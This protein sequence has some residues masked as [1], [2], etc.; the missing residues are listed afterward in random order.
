MIKSANYRVAMACG[1]SLIALAAAAP[2]GANNTNEN[3]G[4]PVTTAAMNA[5]D[6]NAT[7]G[8]GADAGWADAF[9]RP[10]IDGSPAHPSVVRGVA[11]GTA[12]YLYVE[13]ENTAFRSSDA[14]VVA[15]NPT[16]AAGD[17]HKLIIRPCDTIPGGTCTNDTSVVLAPKVSSITGTLAT[18]NTST[19]APGAA[20]AGVSV[21]SRSVAAGATTKWGVEIKLDRAALGIPGSGYFPF[22][23]NAITT[24]PGSLGHPAS[25]I[26]FS[27]PVNSPMFSNASGQ[28]LEN[29][30]TNEPRWGRATLDA[31]LIPAG[32][33]IMG[34]SNSGLDPSKISLTQPNKFTATIANGAGGVALPPPAANISV[35]FEMTQFGLAS[36]WDFTPVPNNTAPTAAVTIAPRQYQ[37]FQAQPWTPDNSAGGNYQGTGQ[38][39]F[40]W[41]G[42]HAHQCINI[43]VMQGGVK[44]TERYYNMDFQTV[45]SPFTSTLMI[46]TGSW[47]KLFPKAKSITLTENFFNTPKDFTWDTGIDGARSIGNHQ[48]I[49]SDFSAD[50]RM[51]QNKILVSD[52]LQLPLRDYKLDTAQLA[53]GQY[54]KIPVQAGVPL[55]L[56]AD[57]TATLGRTSVGPAGL[58]LSD[59][60]FV[61]TAR[62]ARTT[63]TF[64]AIQPGRVVSDGQLVG[65]FDNFRTVVPIQNG[66]TLIPPRGASVL[67]VGIA[68]NVAGI[69]G[70]WRLQAVN[71]QFD[72]KLVTGRIDRTIGG[73]F[74][75]IG[76]NLPTYVVHGMLD[77]GQTITIDGT[78]YNVLVPVGSYG[79]YVYRVRKGFLLPV[80]VR[81]DLFQPVRPIDPTIVQPVR[82]VD[83]RILQPVR[84]DLVQP[85]RPN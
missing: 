84:P 64:S 63:R 47:R 65:S 13:A 12:V 77:I 9:E 8:S 30:S 78:T 16:G 32:L 4:F 46:G 61:R 82:P 72:R 21:A 38:N 31:S 14:V 20:P 37:V 50:S 74:L 75:P 85:V 35:A 49:V 5:P 83:P 7:V 29:S 70:E 18:I 17:Y 23:V 62:M 43:K 69:K 53:A 48:W 34:Y 59:R 10:L 57:G 56:M 66:V 11:N 25:A 81:P 19:G 27:W 73:S 40:T 15:F 45:N 60:R 24:D 44:V 52:R 6:G 33:A 41:F 22:Y 68:G 71:A 39:E 51:L 3:L 54:V 2:A 80:V 58:A 67:Q 36:P 28:V 76:A 55:T 26:N 42:L 79:S 1:L